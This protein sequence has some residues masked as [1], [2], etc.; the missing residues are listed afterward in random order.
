[1]PVTSGTYSANSLWVE[2]VDDEDNLRTFTFTD[3]NGRVILK[4]VQVGATAGLA[5]GDWL[6]TYY[7]YDDLGNLRVVIPPKAIPILSPN[8]WNSATST[9]TALANALYYRYTYDSRGRMVEKRVPGKEVEFLIY[10][11]QNRL[12]ATQDALQRVNSSW[13]YSK[14]DALGRVILTGIIT[15][16][17]TRAS[18]Q[19]LITGNNN[20]V[21]STTATPTTSGGWPSSLGEIL[22]VNYYD[23]YAALSSFAYIKPASP[24]TGFHDNDLNIIGLLAGKKVKNYAS[25][26]LLTTV[27]YY[28]SKG[29][30]IQSVKQHH[31]SNNVRTSIK[32]NFEN[33]YLINSLNGK[34]FFFFVFFEE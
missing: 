32:Y 4:K 7:V 25:N 1:M 15:Q 10:D 19:A 6:W 12:V 2:S 13:T 5:I 26:S 8:S 23:N 30:E 9:N 20:S 31:L 24:H 16:Q 18:V 34:N 29:R 3:K 11:N 28:D 21:L 17:G 33:G 27:Y 14:Y 22:T